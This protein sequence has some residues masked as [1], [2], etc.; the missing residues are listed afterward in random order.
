MSGRVVRD[1]D[2]DA[3]PA[4]TRGRPRSLQPKHCQSYVRKRVAQAL[5]EI[6][7]K[8]IEEAKKGS[9]PHVKILIALSDLSRGNAA[10]SPPQRRG[11]LAAVLLKELKKVPESMS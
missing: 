3:T 2:C 4:P 9:I 1:E 7:E 10:E 5:P 8:F 11:S 6:L